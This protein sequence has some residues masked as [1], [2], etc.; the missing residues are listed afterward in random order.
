MKKILFLFAL[1]VMITTTKAQSVVTL[2]LA[3][4]DTIVNTGTATKV[5]TASAGYSGVIVQVNLTKISGTGAGTVQMQG[6]LDGVTYT[7]VGSA[8]TITNVTTQAAYFSIAGPLPYYIKVL[9]TGSGTESVKQT[10]KYVLRKYD[11]TL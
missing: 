4:G 1:V 9:S 5:F 6:S 11:R 7:N 8:F 3:A 2:P 10:I